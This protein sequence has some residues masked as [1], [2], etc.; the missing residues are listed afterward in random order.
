M[1][2]LLNSSAGAFYAHIDRD[3]GNP[4]MLQIDPFSTEP[5]RLLTKARRVGWLRTTE[6]AAQFGPAPVPTDGSDVKA[7][8]AAPEYRIDATIA[9]T[10]MGEARF[11]AITTM[12]ITASE[13]V[14]PWLP[15][16]LAPIT[17]DSALLPDGRALALQKAKDGTLLWLGLRRHSRLVAPP[18]S[19]WCMAGT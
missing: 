5:V 10:G 14:G 4:V 11:S 2:P 6:S 13:A 7:P 17:V 18:P 16:Y 8:Y 12:R 15:F 1:L 19:D 9:R 3:G